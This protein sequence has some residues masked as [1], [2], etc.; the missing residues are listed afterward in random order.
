[1]RGPRTRHS[2][3]LGVYSIGISNGSDANADQKFDKRHTR[4]RESILPKNLEN[5]LAGCFGNSCGPKTS[6]R[7]WYLKDKGQSLVSGSNSR[8]LKSHIL[9]KGEKRNEMLCGARRPNDANS[10]SVDTCMLHPI[11]A[12]HTHAPPNLYRQQAKFLLSP[13]RCDS[14][15][16]RGAERANYTE[17][18]RRRR[19]S[20]FSLMYKCGVRGRHLSPRIQIPLAAAATATA[21]TT[22]PLPNSTESPYLRNRH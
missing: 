16:W 2:P 9:H 8:R 15:E 18:A 22:E 17:T 5:L 21:T 20:A 6:R 7:K 19:Y 11:K 12:L 10:L 3:R 13:K 1:M 4:R 14:D